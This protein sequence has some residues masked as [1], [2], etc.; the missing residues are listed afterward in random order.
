M[1]VRAMLRQFCYETKPS[2][3]ENMSFFI[4]SLHRR[5]S[6]DSCWNEAQGFL[7]AQASKFNMYRYVTVLEVTCPKYITT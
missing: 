4:S 2:I 5:A 6:P 1:T 7:E 3:D